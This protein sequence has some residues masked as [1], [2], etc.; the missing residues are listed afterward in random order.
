MVR[1]AAQRVANSR[2]RGR[3]NNNAP[4]APAPQQPAAPLPP[5]PGPQAGVSGPSPLPLTL[6]QLAAAVPLPVSGQTAALP[7]TVQ[8]PALLA[9]AQGQPAALPVPAQQTP[10]PTQHIPA[11]ALAPQG[12]VPV[13]P[14]LQIPDPAASQL[15]VPF[16]PAQYPS[17]ST[18]ALVPQQG[19]TSMA[20]VP[21]SAPPQALVTAQ[22]IPAATQ[23]VA[24]QV[25]PLQ[26]PVPTYAQQMAAPVFPMTVPSQQPTSAVT[27]AQPALG[28]F[29]PQHISFAS[30][31]SAAPVQPVQP[32]V[33]VQPTACSPNH[34][35]FMAYQTPAG[36]DLTVYVS[37]GN[38]VAVFTSSQTEHRGLV[39]GVMVDGS[40]RLVR[41]GN[42]IPIQATT[43][44]ASMAP[45][46]LQGSPRHVAGT[47]AQPSQA[48]VPAAN[49]P[50]FLS[51]PGGNMLAQAVAAT[52]ASLAGVAG[53][54]Q[55]TD[56]QGV[57]SAGEASIVIINAAPIFSAIH[58]Q[59]VRSSLPLDSWTE[60]SFSD[61]MRVKLRNLVTE[62]VDRGFFQGPAKYRE[63]YELL[64]IGAPRLGDGVVQD[65][66]WMQS[67]ISF[68]RRCWCKLKNWRADEESWQKA[69]NEANRLL[70]AQTIDR[71]RYYD[72]V[73][74]RYLT[75][76]DASFQKTRGRSAD[77]GK[78]GGNFKPGG[79]GVG[80]KRRDRSEDKKPD[81][82]KAGT[83]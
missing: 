31:H 22:S 1:N 43:S 61:T 76:A 9:T 49:L 46:Q 16:A 48:Q 52:S 39:F 13:N 6:D 11:P 33:S 5:V 65:A 66:T 70:A 67:V 27:S 21:A 57:N 40:R 4:E 56:V 28:L 38:M 12:S 53:R 59:A 2:S 34:S 78:K 72:V 42:D 20:V 64:E 62:V 63:G 24:Q 23:P 7:S 50:P 83:V 60:Q 8:L 54:D 25:F 47:L 37:Q 10:A 73:W 74:S 14:A 80:G 19:L 35:S 81:G 36:E 32:N 71:V 55:V 3:V 29:Q 15:A 58:P 79:S 30:A 44:P 26:T 82:S 77:K 17:P 45:L 75:L 41:V 18:S 69:V 68:F 51:N